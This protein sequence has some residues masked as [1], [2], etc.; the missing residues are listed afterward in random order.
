M[1]DPDITTAVHNDTA[2]G[3]H[4]V[5]IGEL[6]KGDCISHRVD[7]GPMPASVGVVECDTRHV[8]E[9]FAVFDLPPGPYPGEKAVATMA[10]KR[11]TAQFRDYVG[12]GYRRSELEFMYMYPVDRAGWATDR[13]ATCMIV[14]PP[15]NSSYEGS[16]Q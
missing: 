10:E 6:E 14:G 9:V 12:I 4:A 5:G 16:R 11:C 15:T 7:E 13:G 3:S 2:P 1:T 8:H